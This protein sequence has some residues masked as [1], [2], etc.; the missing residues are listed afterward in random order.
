MYVVEPCEK[1]VALNLSYV[2]SLFSGQRFLVQG[3]Y[4]NENS[5]F[6]FFFFFAYLIKHNDP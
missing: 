2:Q 6:F 1:P 4:I 3:L 5:H